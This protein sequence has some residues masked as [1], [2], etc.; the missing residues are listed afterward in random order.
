MTLQIIGHW[1]QTLDGPNQLWERPDG[2]TIESNGDKR[3]WCF[4]R[5]GSCFSGPPIKTFDRAR[6][7]ADREYPY[8]P[9]G[10]AA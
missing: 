8:V 4:T 10:G 9:Q 5:A 2:V 6:K 1:K 7:F 3:W